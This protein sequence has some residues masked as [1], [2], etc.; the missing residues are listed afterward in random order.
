MHTG[1]HKIEPVWAIGL[2]SGT[3]LD[4][5]DVAAIRTDGVE[6]FE[7]G[8][9]LTVPFDDGLRKTLLEAVHSKGDM[10]KTE[11]LITLKHADAVRTF[12]KESGMK[13]AD[14]QV[15]GFHGQ[16]VAHRP[17]EGITWQ[18][19]NGSL[20]AEKTGIDVV[21][22]LRRRDVAAGG[23]G[24]PL[25]PVYHA[26]LAKKLN[27]PVC[28]LNIGGIANVT[29]VGRSEAADEDIL[30][31]DIIAFDTGPGNAMLNDWVLSK[32]GV[33]FDQDGR[34]ALAGKVHEEIVA[35]YMSDAFFNIHPPKSLDRNAFTLH[36]L[37]YLSLEDGAATLTAFAAESM[38][39]AAQYF[40]VP[41]KQWL[42][43]G[44][45]RHNPAMMAALARALSFTSPL[46]GEVAQSAGEGEKYMDTPLPS[47]LPQG[48]RGIQRLPLPSREREVL[49]Q[50]VESVGWEGDAMEA[51]AFAYLAVRS[52][53]KLPLTVPTTTGA[54][55]A[56]TGGGF[57][58]A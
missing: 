58:P 37:E 46:M 32:T 21:C 17:D 20:L 43:T 6:V 27:L 12:L 54:N 24:A 4:G 51:Q 34:L 57:F 29:W 50:P 55:R 16:T 15:I 41:A 38:A 9:W 5:I 19:G 10:A 49:V 39:A 48:E 31:H 40:P 23:Q 56:V 53:R 7:R 14:V 30:S 3:S 22:D 1:K 33:P 11:N 47:P 45:G 44:G 26:A 13:A 2:M 8:A 42:V 18:I 52:L 28:V 25:V 36:A 35:R